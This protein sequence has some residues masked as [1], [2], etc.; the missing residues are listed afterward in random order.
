MSFKGKKIHFIGIGGTAMAGAA[1]MADELGMDVRG[2]DQNLYPPTVDELRESG[3][4][5]KE[6]YAAEN[7]AY[8]PDLIVLGNAISRGNPELEEA[9]NRRIK[10]LSLPE[11]I[12]EAVI[13]SRECLVIAGTHGKTT[14]TSLV[15]HILRANG[16]DTGFMIGGICENFH[17]SAEVGSANIF[18]IE[19]DEYDTSIFDPRSKFLSYRPT[20]A[21]I[22]NIEFDHA[23]IFADLTEVERAFARL[24]KIIPQNGVLVVNADNPSALKISAGAKTRIITFGEAKN[25][26][27]RLISSHSGKAT[28]IRYTVRG[29]GKT[30]TSPL[31]G[32]HNALNLL[33]A[34]ALL[35]HRGL[36]DEQLQ[37]ALNTFAGIKRRLQVRLENKFA[38]VIE[39]FA[40]HPTA[41]RANL[42]TLRELYPGRRLVVLIEPR[43]NTMVRSFFQ[44]RL[45]SALGV[46]DIIFSDAIYRAEKYADH[47]R[48]NLQKLRS[49]LELLG[50]ETHFLPATDRA[51]FVLD[52]LKP[53]DLV[54]FM[55]NGS[56]SGLIGETVELIS[57]TR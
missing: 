35:E 24:V 5:F 41:I 1:L 48:L 15:A 17:R 3:I 21:L 47:E 14:T 55:T 18:V 57:R 19:G 40:H 22:N 12:A 23:D 46:A 6:G 28:E 30:L 20:H 4:A 34:L 37:K 49:D 38:T 56:F 13:D 27:Y 2:S 10:I 52:K 29:S 9:L 39:D 16:V 25:A 45:V 43:S 26:D 54:C 53:G 42:E 8:T 33:A 50:R 44:E 51:A 11:F 36:T 7:L 32:R 31:Q